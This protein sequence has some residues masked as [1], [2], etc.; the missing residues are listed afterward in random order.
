MDSMPVVRGSPRRGCRDLVLHHRRIRR[1][2]SQLED[3]LCGHDR[4]LDDRNVVRHA[5]GGA[6]GDPLWD[7]LHCLRQAAIRQSRLDDHGVPPVCLDHRLELPAADLLRQV[8]VT[9]FDNARR[10]RCRERRPCR[11]CSFGACVRRCLPCSA[12]AARAASSAFRWC[13]FLHRRHRPMDDVDAA[14]EA[15][16]CHRRCQTLC[17]LRK[18]AMGLRDGHRNWHRQSAQLVALY[19]SHGA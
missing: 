7:Q 1:L 16:R 11:S 5:G 17:R 12:C 15:G 6:D 8:G 2:L 4:R 9:A 13:C 19:R 10:G 18:S 3:G 14:N